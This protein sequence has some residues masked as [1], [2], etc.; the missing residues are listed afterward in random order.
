MDQH[1]DVI[2]KFPE[3]TV[4][5]S[6]FVTL[7]AFYYLVSTK[8]EDYNSGS[9]DPYELNTIMTK[10]EDKTS[11]KNIIPTCKSFVVRI[12]GL[13]S[14]GLLNK[15]KKFAK[16]DDDSPHSKEMTDAMIETAYDLQTYF[17]PTAIYVNSNE[18]L[19]FFPS[20]VFKTTS[21][22]GKPMTHPYS[23]QITKILSITSS[24][25]TYYFNRH[26]Q[27][28]FANTSHENDIR[29]FT[30]YHFQSKIVS[31]GNDVDEM[32]NIANYLIWRA[33]GICKLSCKTMYAAYY[34]GKHEITNM[35]EQEREHRLAQMGV[36]YDDVDDAIRYGLFLR[37]TDLFT[38]TDLTPTTFIA[39]YLLTNEDSLDMSDLSSIYTVFMHNFEENDNNDYQFNIADPILDDVMPDYIE[40]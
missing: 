8:Y 9:A 17:K 37:G 25:A 18:F 5:L 35:S 26:L 34:L 1:Y 38:I 33:V 6:L 40:P 22:R 11:A 24:V 23:G 16:D 21:K 2:H 14:R 12:D 3:Y 10:F 20:N 36:T 4:C 15:L 32:L 30:G 27:E 39:Q 28:Q 13:R 29:S 19:L 7:L 31:F